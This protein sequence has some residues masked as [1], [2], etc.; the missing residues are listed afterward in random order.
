[1]TTKRY[2][3][4]EVEALEERTVLSAGFRLAP[5]A[6]S[7]VAH[8]GHHAQQVLALDGSVSGTWQKRL[9]LPDTG[10]DQVLTGSGVVAPLG[11]VRLRGE[12]HTPGF[13]SQGKTLGTIKL[14]NA[15]GS[16]SVQM[17]GPPQPGFSVPPSTFHYTI[18]GGTGQ[19]VGASGSGSATFHEQPAHGPACPPN[20]I[21]PTILDVA[22]FT[23][24]FVPR[25][26]VLAV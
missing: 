19:Y 2:W 21:C 10:G 18:L 3:R 9:T 8:H 4:P 6:L 20:T 17:V 16:V 22:T 23:L 15:K 11:H 14:T 5:I 13:I 1:M 26:P 24:T 25:P 7:P 12:L